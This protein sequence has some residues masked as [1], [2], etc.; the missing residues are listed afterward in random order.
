MGSRPLKLFALDRPKAAAKFRETGG[1]SAGGSFLAPRNLGV[2]CGAAG[3]QESLTLLK[4]A[5]QV[6]VTA[7]RTLN[8]DIRSISAGW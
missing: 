3:H 6:R 1:C 8:P 5:V 4:N 7:P 2:R